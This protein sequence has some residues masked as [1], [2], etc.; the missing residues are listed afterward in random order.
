[1]EEMIK[2]LERDEKLGQDLMKKRVAKKKKQNIIEAGPDAESFKKWR[3]QNNELKK[4]GAAYAG[5]QAD[6]DC[7]DDAVQ[8]DV[9]KI[10]KG[11]TEITKEKFFSAAEAP[12]FVKEAQDKAM[13]SGDMARR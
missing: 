12:T 1:M 9:W 5:D 8:V 13:A 10:A 11:G 4:L 6:P 3:A 2:Q 7:P